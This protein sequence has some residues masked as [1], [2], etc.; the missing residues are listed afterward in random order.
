[1]ISKKPKIGKQSTLESIER[2]KIGKSCAENQIIF[3]H[4]VIVGPEQVEE[5]SQFIGD[6]TQANKLGCEYE[7]KLD[8]NRQIPNGIEAELNAKNSSRRN[9]VKWFVEYLHDKNALSIFVVYTT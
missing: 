5:V 9:V 6:S 8:S 1:M 2:Q 4:I 3:A 7:K